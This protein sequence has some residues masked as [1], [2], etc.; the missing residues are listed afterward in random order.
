LFTG[1]DLM[2][3]ALVVAAVLYATSP[4]GGGAEVKLEPLTLLV[5][6]IVVGMILVSLT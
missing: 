6:L 1:L 3:I 4:P 2:V 5:V